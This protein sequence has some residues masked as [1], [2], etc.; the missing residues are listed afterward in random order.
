MSDTDFNC[1]MD[2]QALDVMLKSD[3]EMHIMPINVALAMEFMY[4]E[5]EERLRGKH[6][7]GDYLVDRWYQHLDGSREARWIWDLALIGAMIHPEWAS[8]VEITSSKE[9]G[10]KKI[11]YYNAID[12]EKVRDEF[13]D[14]LNAYF[15]R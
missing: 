5:T 13:F 12:G 8:S 2:V 4:K 10:N 6:D 9:N 1:V 7:L 14:T 3:V 15:D 11:T